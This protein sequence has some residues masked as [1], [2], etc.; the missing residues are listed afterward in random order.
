MTPTPD[1][2]V[3]LGLAELLDLAAR[4]IRADDIQNDYNHTAGFVARRI[5]VALRAI[6]KGKG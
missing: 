4:E 6:A 2:A 3:L 5:A 1:P